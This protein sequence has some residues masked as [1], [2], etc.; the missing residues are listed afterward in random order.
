MNSRI[1]PVGDED[2][3]IVLDGFDDVGEGSGRV[4]HREG[5]QSLGAKEEKGD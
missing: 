3:I 5:A 2:V 1:D 4:D